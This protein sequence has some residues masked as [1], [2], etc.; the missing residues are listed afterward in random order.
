[1]CGRSGIVME[2]FFEIFFR[3]RVHIPHLEVLKNIDSKVFWE[4]ICDRSQEGTLSL[5]LPRSW[6]LFSFLERNSFLQWPCS[7]IS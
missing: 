2:I 7:P 4:G 6:I 5:T 1:M 3:E